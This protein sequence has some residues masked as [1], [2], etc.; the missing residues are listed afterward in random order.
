MEEKKKSYGEMQD[1]LLQDIQEAIQRIRTSDVY[2]LFLGF[3][4]LM[5]PYSLHNLILI[6]SQCP[7]ATYVG[8]MKKL[9][10]KVGRRVKKGERA[11]R[12]LRP[13]IKKVPV[14]ADASDTQEDL[15]GREITVFDEADS[16]RGYE[17]R[18]IVVGY[19][20]A[21]VFDISQTEGED[22]PAICRPLVGETELYVL[23]S[24]FVR[25]KGY[26]IIEQENLNGA[27]GATDYKSIWIEAGNSQSQ[28][29]KTLIHEYGHNYLEHNNTC[30][31]DRPARELQAET[32]AYLVCKDLGLDTSSYSFQYLTHWSEGMD[33]K[34]FAAVVSMAITQAKH[35]AQ[36]FRNYAGLTAQ[37]EN[38]QDESPE[39]GERK[40]A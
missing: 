8:G 17:Y 38:D 2:K 30:A 13:V 34:K 27:H 26:E 11:I 10:N 25:D 14:K 19:R 39:E 5:H 1:R 23:F 21:Y 3:I 15:F 6:W 28:K 20:V 32:V 40:A 16:Q 33:D 12:I 7:D 31:G 36:D 24:R 9:W 35:I 22:L 37:I 18:R 29:L 4:N